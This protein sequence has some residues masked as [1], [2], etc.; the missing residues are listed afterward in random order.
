MTYAVKRYSNRKLYDLQ[1]SHYVTLNTLERLI[2]EGKELSVVDA[3]SGED[4][5]KVTLLQILLERER[6]HRG[7]LTP[8]FLHQVIRD[9]RGGQA[10][11]QEAP[12]SPSEGAIPTHRGDDQTRGLRA[13]QGSLPPSG[14]ADASEG[15]SESPA[16]EA[17]RLRTEIEGLS[18][19]RRDL[20]GKLHESGD[21]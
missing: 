1:Q 13:P 2:E 6:A 17:G 16:A 5:T 21:H 20:E 19:K 9:S 12:G 7:A 18:K 3:S 15:T 4:L 11:P 14:G 10:P 8:P